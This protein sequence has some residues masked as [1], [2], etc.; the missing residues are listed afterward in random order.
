MLL[1]EPE[2]TSVFFL[3]AVS[4][5]EHKVSFKY[6]AT[7]QSNERNISTSCHVVLGNTVCSANRENAVQGLANWGKLHC[8]LCTESKNWYIKITLNGSQTSHLQKN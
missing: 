5:S 4:F 3:S 8:M 1:W 6:T 2:Q 7:S